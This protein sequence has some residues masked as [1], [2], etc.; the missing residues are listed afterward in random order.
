M[1]SVLIKN[2]TIV[3]KN[4]NYHQQKKNIFIEDGV[5]K[6]ISNETPL[7]QKTI[8][9]D[10]CMVSIGW[11]DMRCFIGEPGFEHKENIASV[12]KS[13]AISGF[14]AIASLPNTSPVV[15]SKDT[16]SYI[17][18]QSQKQLVDIFPIAALTVNMKG[19]ELTEMMELHQYGAVAFSDAEHCVHHAGVMVRAL[20]YMKPFN[21]LVIQHAEEQKLTMHGQ[22][23]E[24]ITSTYLGLKGIPALAEELIIKRDIELLEYAG[25]G[26]L[27]FSRITTKNSVEIIRKAKAE[28]KNIT[29]DVTVAHLVLNETMLTDFDTN[30]KLN[31]P[32]RTIEDQKALWDGLQDGTIDVIVTDH[33]GQDTES[34]HLEFDMAENG[35]IALETAFGLLLKYKPQNM[36]LEQLLSKISINP[37]KILGIDIP[38]ISE[39]KIANITL[40]DT[41]NTWIFTQNDIQ[42]KSKNTPFVGAE[43]KGK[44]LGV[45]NKEKVISN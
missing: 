14:T 15:Q 36:S 45:V 33:H 3:D 35:M 22:M 7:A 18:S 34:K 21:G 20:Q 43:L 6:S 27:H 19:E 9:A 16:L 25:T 31:P 37:R 8:E 42:S 12:C 17:I 1:S 41:E 29:C 26:R 40:F 11:M 4:S 23:N 30:L 39:G 10:G 5:I 32:L 2:A 28:G 38:Q 24:G 44:V 13:A